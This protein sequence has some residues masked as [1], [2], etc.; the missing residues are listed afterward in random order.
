MRS[1]VQEALQFL[2]TL[3]CFFSAFRLPLSGTVAAIKIRISLRHRINLSTKSRETRNTNAWSALAGFNTSRLSVN[4]HIFSFLD[5]SFVLHGR[6]P[7]R[8]NRF[9][10][11]SAL[12][13]K[14]CC[15]RAIVIMDGGWKAEKNAV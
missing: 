11:K 5:V 4:D 2:R 3:R 13:R 15:R 12:W 9:Q 10:R 6:I 14:E 8:F 1:F 7:Q